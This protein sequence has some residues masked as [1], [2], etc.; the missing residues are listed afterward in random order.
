MSNEVVWPPLSPH[1]ALVSS[2]SGR[3]KYESMQTS[4]IKRSTTTTNL[5]D[6]IRAARN[7]RN[8]AVSDQEEDDH[9]DDEEILQLKLAAIE[10][11]L[12]LKKLQQSKARVSTPAHGRSRPNSS[13]G[14]SSA[15]PDAN[16]WHEQSQNAH[17]QVEVPLSPTRRIQPTPQPKSPSRVLLGIDKGAR[18]TDV[19]L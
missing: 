11:K 8:N 17:A 2:P 14:T 4:P 18:A 15:T 5:L 3:K 12:R 13:H 10:A 16:V 1:A 9:D 6:R 7:D 19:S